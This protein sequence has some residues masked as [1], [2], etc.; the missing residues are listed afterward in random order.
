MN[1]IILLKNQPAVSFFGK[2]QLIL[3]PVDEHP[4]GCWKMKILVSLTSFPGGLH[5]RWIYLTSSYM[6]IFKLQLKSQGS[7]HKKIYILKNGGTEMAGIIFI[8]CDMKSW[9]A[10]T[11]IVDQ[12]IIGSRDTSSRDASFHFLFNS[13]RYYELRELLEP[14]NVWKSRWNKEECKNKLAKQKW[15][16]LEENNRNN[17]QMYAKYY[18]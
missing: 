9:S 5:I 14:L 1:E 2:K 6:H 7:Y 15:I 10:S 18:A 16:D 4:E 3:H 8:W 11:R 13:I 17:Y 12:T